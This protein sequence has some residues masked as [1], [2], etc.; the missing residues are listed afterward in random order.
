MKIRIQRNDMTAKTGY[1]FR[2]LEEKS[3][4]FLPCRIEEEK[5]AVTMCF[6]LQG[7]KSFEELKGEDTYIKLKALLETGEL[8]ELSRCLTLILPRKS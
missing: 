3:H 8:K 2:R 5:D 4:L 7:M 6:D 1:D